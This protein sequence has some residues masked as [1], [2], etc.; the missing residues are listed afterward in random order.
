L[1]EKDL[2]LYYS[3]REVSELTGVP[4]TAL[5]YWEKQF[6]ELNPRKTPR[7]ARQYTRDD[8][9][10]IKLINHLLKDKGLTIASARQRLKSSKEV[11]VESSEIVERLKRVRDELQAMLDEM[12]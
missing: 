9:E 5:R 2:K 6:R 4:D 1:L 8:I 3:I 12:T 10:L 7:G 11:V